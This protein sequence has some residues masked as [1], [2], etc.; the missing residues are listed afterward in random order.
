MSDP[1]LEKRLREEVSYIRWLIP[2]CIIGI[3]SRYRKHSD[4]LEEAAEALAAMDR[5]HMDQVFATCYNSL[6]RAIA[7]EGYVMEAANG[8]IT[9]RKKVIQ[10]TAKDCS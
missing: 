2:S 5:S 9:I 4:L 6:C 8:E 1:T 3:R 10:T 7:A